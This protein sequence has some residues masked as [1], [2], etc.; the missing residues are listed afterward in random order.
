MHILVITVSGPFAYIK[1]YPLTRWVTL[2]APMCPQHTA[3]I[4]SIEPDN[5]VLL[6]GNSCNH[7][8]NFGGCTSHRYELRLNPGYV[9][10]SKWIGGM[11][12]P[13]PTP[14]G[15]YDPKKWRFWLSLPAPDVFAAINPV[16]AQIIKAGANTPKANYPVG[17]RF[18]Y[19]E[20]DGNAIHLFGNGEEKKVFKVDDYEDDHMLLEIEYSGPVRDDP[21]HEDAV[22]CFENIM[23]G[24]GLPWSIYFPPSHAGPESTKQNDC[25]AAV[26]GVGFSPAD[27]EHH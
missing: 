12:L 5:Q 14:E 7:Q 20:W 9:P 13:C 2:M 15:D 11:P 3:G 24:L 10:S 6:A 27:S 22:S 19:K 17:V 16:E 25:L 1:D 8:G 23:R 21:D 4:S 18:I 26:A